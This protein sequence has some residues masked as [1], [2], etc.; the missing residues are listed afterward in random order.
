M[1][2]K[3]LVPLAVSELSAA[4]LP[5]ARELAARLDIAVVLLHVMSQDE[6][7]TISDLQAEINSKVEIVKRQAEEARKKLGI[8]GKVKVTG[9]VAIGSPADEIT[10]YATEN[11]IDLILMATHARSGISR[12]I[13]GS[14]GDKVVRNVKVPVWLVRPGAPEE[15]INEGWPGAKIVVPLDGSEGAE[16]VFPHIDALAQQQGKEPV[17]VIL[18]RSYTRPLPPPSSEH[19]IILPEEYMT[20]EIEF[21]QR[22]A[23]QYLKHMSERLTKREFKVS[24]RVVEG[25]AADSL[26]E[27]SEENPSCV[28]LMTTHARSGLRRSAQGS[29]A[30]KLLQ[31]ASCPVMLVR[32]LE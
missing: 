6:R 12:M 26:I 13:I 30:G 11:D 20:A 9:E 23:E 25:G 31:K 7:G 21:R 19:A 28:I 1:Y 8:D 24:T 2:K 29:V 4:T 16:A 14:V 10:R 3:M 5:Y 27:Y 17:E 18:W 22:S 32:I 15:A